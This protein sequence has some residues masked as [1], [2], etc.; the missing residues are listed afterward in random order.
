VAAQG[1]NQA[2]AGKPG[3]GDD[4]QATIRQPALGL[5]DDLARPIDHRFVPP[6]LFAAPTLGRGENGQQR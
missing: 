3:I 4:D 5:Q 1:R 6:A 2:D